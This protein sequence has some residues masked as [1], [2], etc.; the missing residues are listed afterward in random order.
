FEQNQ[1]VLETYIECNII[2]RTQSVGDVWI[3]WVYELDL[4]HEVFLV[5]GNPLFPLNNMPDSPELFLECVGLDSYGHR[6]YSLSTPGKHRYNWKSPPP[7]VDDSVIDDYNARQPVPSH[8]KMTIV[9][10][11]QAPA[12][13]GSRESARIGLYEVLV[14]EIMQAWEIGHY[15]RLLE[16]VPDRTEI[17]RELLPLGLKLIKVSVARM[18]FSYEKA[19]EYLVLPELEDLR[20]ESSPAAELEEFSWLAP[21][22][23][24]QIVTHLDDERNAKK[25]VLGLVDQIILRRQSGNFAYGILFSFFHAIVVQVDPNNEF[26]STTTL[27]FL[28]NFH[29]T[30]PSTPGILA[31]ARLGYHCFTAP[32]TN[33]V[34]STLPSHHFLNQVPLEV[35]EHIAANLDPA[36]LESFRAV[37]PLFEPATDALLRYAYVENYRLL[38]VVRASPVVFERSESPDVIIHLFKAFSAIVPSDGTFVP[39][40]RVGNRARGAFSF[41]FPF[42]GETRKVAYE[43]VKHDSVDS[44]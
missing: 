6:S 11:L 20:I 25:V 19:D 26:K 39:E 9:D 15:V 37:T 5:D 44:D 41:S 27:Q 3:E 10:L 42:A 1:D 7:K 23:C 21:D 29:S 43:V 30:S 36:D 34:P 40:L 17:P 38:N 13:A 14:G 16:A 28:P 33:G 12:S 8:S 31:V 22:I 18:V 2:T 32:K 35:L 4:D 24:M